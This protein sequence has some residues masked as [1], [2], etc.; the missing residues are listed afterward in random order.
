MILPLT[1]WSDFVSGDLGWRSGSPLRLK[2][3]NPNGCRGCSK[4]TG[5]YQDI[6]LAISQILRNETQIGRVARVTAL[7]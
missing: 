7:E 6:A 2:S 1:V 4:K 5:S 3:P